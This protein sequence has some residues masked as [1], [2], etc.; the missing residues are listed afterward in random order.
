MLREAKNVQEVTCLHSSKMFSF[1]FIDF[2]KCIVKVNSI[3][4]NA[5]RQQGT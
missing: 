4:F 1:G 2:G 3:L 5:M